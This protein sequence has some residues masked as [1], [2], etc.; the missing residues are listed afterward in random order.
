MD[1]THRELVLQRWN[2]IQHVLL[3]ELRHDVGALTPK[4]VKVIHILEWVRPRLLDTD[5]TAEPNRLSL[6]S[7]QAHR[8]K[9]VLK[10]FKPCGELLVGRRAM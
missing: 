5:A 4:L 9:R 6:S 8:F 7:W 10:P 2:V 3:P 1:A